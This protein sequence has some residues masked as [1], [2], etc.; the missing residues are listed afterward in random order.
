MRMCFNINGVMICPEIPDL[1][2]ND[3]LGPSPDPWIKFEGITEIEARQLQAISMV[4][5]LVEQFPE[6]HHDALWSI[7]GHAVEDFSRRLPDVTFEMP[8][9]KL[10]RAQ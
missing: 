6:A 9:Y 4:S 10:E 5:N 2:R 3:M 8:N 7:I 1:I